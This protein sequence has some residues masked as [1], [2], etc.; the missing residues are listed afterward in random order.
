MSASGPSGPL[1]FVCGGGGGWG[2][3]GGGELKK[4]FVLGL[5][6]WYTCIG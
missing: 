4:L 5:Q 3:G 1:V 2:G 6:A